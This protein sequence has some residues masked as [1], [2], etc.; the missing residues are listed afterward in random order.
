MRLVVN[1]PFGWYALLALGVASLVYKLALWLLAILW[2]I[3]AIS[4]PRFFL[5]PVVVGV[6]V[7]KWQFAVPVVTALLVIFAIY[8]MYVSRKKRKA[9]AI[10]ALD[11]DSKN[12]NSTPQ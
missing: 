3:L 11:D 2:L 6:C 7:V 9:R 1:V 10:L 8:S 5:P 4:N 12:Q